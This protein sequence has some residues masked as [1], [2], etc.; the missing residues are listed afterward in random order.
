MG[1]IRSDVEA[2]VESQLVDLGAVPLA[3][4]RELDGTML[5]RS[6]AHVL[7]QVRYGR[8][9]ADG[10]GSGTERVD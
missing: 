1:S 8:V 7:E 9:S 6:L 3:V 2:G 10:G 4:L 5:H